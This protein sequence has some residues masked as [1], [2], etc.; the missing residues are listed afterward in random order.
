MARRRKKDRKEPMRNGLYRPSG[1][2]FWWMQYRHN[3]ETIK[4]STRCVRRSDAETVRAEAIAAIAAGR[5]IV[6]SEKVTFD[7]GVQLLDADAKKK[8][9]KSRRKLAHPRDYFGDKTKLVNITTARVWAYEA[10]RLAAGAKR[11]TVNQEL[12]VLRR[13]F[14]LAIEAGRI[15]TKP[16]IKTPDPDNA[17]KGFVTEKQCFAVRDELP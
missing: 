8:G 7:E 14:N 16:V 17:R 1:T 2:M 12:S 11:A 10:H 9:N 3:G 6:H 15:A 13:L 4:K 5:L